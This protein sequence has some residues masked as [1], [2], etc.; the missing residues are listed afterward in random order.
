MAEQ[1]G[2]EYSGR[3]ECKKWVPINRDKE[4]MVGSGGEEARVVGK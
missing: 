2:V 4:R 1:D 3:K